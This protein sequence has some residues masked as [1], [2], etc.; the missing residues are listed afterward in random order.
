MIAGPRKKTF[1]VQ[2]NFLSQAEDQNTFLPNPALGIL[3]MLQEKSFCGE[4]L[5]FCRELS[6]VQSMENEKPL[7]EFCK[8]SL[9]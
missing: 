9:L 5:C 2:K 6:E 8:G 4:S 1:P 7:T 3:C